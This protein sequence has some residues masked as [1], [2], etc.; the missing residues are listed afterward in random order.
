MRSAHAV[1][2]CACL[3]W[4]CWLWSLFIGACAASS[5]PGGGIGA[6]VVNPLFVMSHAGATP[7]PMSTKPGDEV[8]DADLSRRA[9]QLLSAL[10]L[11]ISSTVCNG[12][13]CVVVVVAAVIQCSGCCL[14]PSVNGL[15][16]LLRCCDW[17][18]RYQILL[19]DSVTARCCLCLVTER[20]WPLRCPSGDGCAVLH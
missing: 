6:V 11:R 18:L 9:L 3:C 20:R 17:C 13:H 4:L 7:R 16:A 15:C 5:L 12:W 8:I 19:C 1:L 10:D 14:R 2:C